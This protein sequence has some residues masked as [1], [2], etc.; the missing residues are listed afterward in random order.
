MSPRASWPAGLVLSLV[1]TA[2][3]SV[4]A[5]RIAVQ[6]TATT[7][8]LALD[9]APTLRIVKIAELTIAA[10]GARGCSV[11]I[12]NGSLVR[13]GGS[14]I[15][16]QVL[17]VERGAPAPSATT[18]APGGYRFAI[19]DRTRTVDVYIKYQPSIYQTPGSYTASDAIDAV[20][21]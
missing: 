7:T 21:N 10:T 17:V 2:T 15:S 5:A 11:W 6:P 18:F 4:L 12:S 20:D 19:A 14:P 3:G 16:F 8:D 13:A 9:G 1:M